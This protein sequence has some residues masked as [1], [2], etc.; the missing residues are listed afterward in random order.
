MG[1]II[2][3]RSIELSNHDN[4]TVGFVTEG[5]YYLSVSI[6]RLLVRGYRG[7]VYQE[8]Y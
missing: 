7:E 4:P 6:R 8:P 3:Y 5:D 1:S 2:N